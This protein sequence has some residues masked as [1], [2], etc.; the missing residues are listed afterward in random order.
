[1]LVRGATLVEVLVALLIMGIG[2]LGIASLQA[3]S[4]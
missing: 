2:M 3:T 4:L 1:M